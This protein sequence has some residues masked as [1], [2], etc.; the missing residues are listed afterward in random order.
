MEAEELERGR[1]EDDVEVKLPGMGEGLALLL[2]EKV[3]PPATPELG[4]LNG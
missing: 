3:D 1:A 2:E 4:A